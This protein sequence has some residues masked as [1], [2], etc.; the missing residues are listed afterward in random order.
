RWGKIGKQRIVDEGP[1]APGPNTGRTIYGGAGETTGGAK[2]DMTTFDE[3]LVEN[4]VAFMKKAKG[5]RQ[6]VLRLAQHHARARLVVPLGEVQELDER[7]DQL[8]SR[9]SRN[10]AA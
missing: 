5:C 7:G 2:Y 3:V 4:S 8:R 1:L 10:G 6:A 9:G